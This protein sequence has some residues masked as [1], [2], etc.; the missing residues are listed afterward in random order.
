MTVAACL[1]LSAC[2]GSSGS[3]IATGTAP[4][5]TPSVGVGSS[6]APSDS[7]PADGGSGGS[8]GA[9][10]ATGATGGSGGATGATT[11]AAGP[12]ACTGSQITVGHGGGEGAAGH[13]A[14]VLTFTNWTDH[15]CTL[16]GYPGVAGLDSADRQV[17]QARRTLRGMM[18]GA[19]PG[20]THAPTVLVPA[21]GVVSA[22]V[23]ASDVPQGGATACPT[24][25]GLLVTP[26]APGRPPVWWPTSSS[27]AAPGWRSTPWWP[28]P[29]AT[30]TEVAA[31]PG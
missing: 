27:P 20:A 28:A 18:G 8:T 14:V 6:A 7:A 30:R 21:H 31:G 9:T 26:P 22:R 3:P 19:A 23:E 12:A 25:A 11:A 10:S 17:V 29:P 16:H 1:A 13:L 2:S 15:P 24:Y 4:A 5:A